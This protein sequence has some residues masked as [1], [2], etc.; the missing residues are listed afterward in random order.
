MT[1][2]T[3]NLIVEHII[4][5]FWSRSQTPPSTPQATLLIKEGLPERIFMK[6]MGA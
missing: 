4:L 1:S 6:I 3:Y 2:L 5:M